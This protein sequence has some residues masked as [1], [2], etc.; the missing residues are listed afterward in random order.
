LAWFSVPFSLLTVKTVNIEREY[1][2]H[3]GWRIIQPPNTAYVYF[4]CREEDIPD[5]Q[6]EDPLWQPMCTVCCCHSED[7]FICASL[8]PWLTPLASQ[9]KNGNPTDNTAYA[10]N[11]I[12]LIWQAHYVVFCP[13]FFSNQLT[14]LATKVL[15]AQ[16][17]IYMQETIDYW[18]PIR[19]RTM[20]H[21]TYHWE[22]TVSEPLAIDYAYDP[23][24]IVDL[25]I[26]DEEE[27]AENAESFALA[28]MAIYLQKTFN[29]PEPPKPKGSRGT[30][31][32]ANLRE[33][34]L[35]SPPPGWKRPVAADAA[36]FRP[37][38]T[39]V[40]MLEQAGPLNSGSAP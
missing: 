9:D 8:A 35:A 30:I 1:L 40:K 31:A 26:S 15:T 33:V 13:Q 24:A 12:G 10:F 2:I 25:A 29:L 22:Y 6:K 17:D 39:G 27:A 14:S 4:Y 36:Q 5:K 19:A 7:V 21:E 32:G 18:R 23:Q 20:F 37:D 3:W 11:D 34:H 28:A 38:M 16:G